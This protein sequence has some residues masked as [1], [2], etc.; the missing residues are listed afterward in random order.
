MLCDACVVLFPFSLLVIGQNFPQSY[1]P[2]NTSRFPKLTRFDPI[3]ATFY[4]EW[5]EK[6]W[7]WWS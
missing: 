3:N 7:G 6:S 1:D 2:I 4:R 5:A